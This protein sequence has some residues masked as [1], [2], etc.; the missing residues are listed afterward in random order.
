MR[1]TQSYRLVSAMIIAMLL[2]LVVRMAGAQTSKPTGA[3]GVQLSV[4][5]PSLQGRPVMISALRDGKIVGQHEE[6]SGNGSALR[7][8]NLTEGLYDVRVEGEGVV[9]EEKHGVHVFG[10]Q[11]VDLVFDLRP[12]KGV[13]IVEYATGPLSREE[14]A[15]RLARLEAAVANLAK[16]RSQN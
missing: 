14:V 16:T 1:S 6:R 12:G 4:T 3:I 15:T 5:T 11:E 2:L 10:G 13:H 9:T 7:G 8:G